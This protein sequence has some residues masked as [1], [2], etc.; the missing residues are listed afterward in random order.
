ME[1][2]AAGALRLAATRGDVR[3]MDA[4]ARAPA[5]NVDADM[6]GFTALMAATTM[7]QEAAVLWL[8]QHGASLTTL[9]DD[10]WRDSVL[11]YAAAKGHMGIVQ[12]LLAY[13]APPN[14]RNAANKL[15]ADVAHDNGHVEVQEYLLLVAVGNT[16]IPTREEVDARVQEL[17]AEAAAQNQ[18]KSPKAAAA[19]AAAAGDGADQDPEIV[20]E[21]PF[22]EGL[23]SGYEVGRCW[24]RLC[25]AVLCLLWCVHVWM[26]GV[27]GTRA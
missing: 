10:G 23:L 12:A 21:M 11:H 13:G 3:T 22:H 27:L 16:P 1:R 19:Y 18:A 9:K 6:A 25:S 2:L 24:R 7:G 15:P 17:A 14:V 26:A 5:F 8:L 20:P 4:L